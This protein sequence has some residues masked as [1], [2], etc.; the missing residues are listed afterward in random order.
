LT[1]LHPER[2]LVPLGVCI[3]WDELPPIAA[4]DLVG[5][6]GRSIFI[7]HSRLRLVGR[8]VSLLLRSTPFS[9][10]ALESHIEVAAGFQSATTSNDGQS[11]TPRHHTGAHSTSS[12]QAARHPSTGGEF[13]TALIAGLLDGDL[14][15]IHFSLSK[16][17]GRGFGSTPTGD[18]WITGIV[19]LGH[20][21]KTTGLISRRTWRSFCTALADVPG[22]A[23][24]P[25]AAEMLRHASRAA[26]PTPLLRVARLLGHPETQPDELREACRKLLAVGSS[27]GGDWLIGMLALASAITITR[28]QN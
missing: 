3:P 14:K 20:R 9:M 7:G 24:T 10:E 22:K 28:A 23:T 19:A 2:E 8:G 26:F 18:D 12:G 21:A 15:A 25:V 16:L 1:L 11:W 13:V 17:I 4:G 27:S 6:D 5:I